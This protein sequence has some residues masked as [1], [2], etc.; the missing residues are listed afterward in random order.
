M[1]V[2]DD[3]TYLS[4][5]GNFLRET[6]TRGSETCSIPTFQ[7]LR[8]EFPLPSPPDSEEESFEDDISLWSKEK[9]AKWIESIVQE[10]ALSRY[11]S[12]Q[13]INLF[14][15]DGKSLL[16]LSAEDLF[17]RDPELG[18]IIS[19][20]L[21]DLQKRV[22]SYLDYNSWLK[23]DKIMWSNTSLTPSS[24]PCD[25]S[26]SEVEYPPT[27]YRDHPPYVPVAPTSFPHIFTETPPWFPYVSLPPP[28]NGALDSRPGGFNLGT[29]NP[30][31]D[32]EIAIKKE[33]NFPASP[34]FYDGTYCDPFTCSTYSPIYKLQRTSLP[35]PS[36]V[37]P[38]QSNG[39]KRNCVNVDPKGIEGIP[40]TAQLYEFI[41]KVLNNPINQHILSWKDKSKGIFYINDTKAFARLWGLHRNSESMSYE[42]LSRAMRYY[43]RR[44]ILEQIKGRRLYKFTA[45]MNKQIMDE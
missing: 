18:P 20:K 3:N 30:V 42:K 31:E 11:P 34:T 16:Y 41:L 13:T 19:E 33:P 26:D 12:Q 40:K 6:Q 8:Y 28:Y 35:P 4:D 25:S 36:H 2:Q 14:V 5:V 27:N 21:M 7:E 9:V 24:S 1:D 37:P 29:C 10:V 44:N 23:Q 38:V 39:C 22:E 15:M 32:V 43:Y 45:K 17:Q